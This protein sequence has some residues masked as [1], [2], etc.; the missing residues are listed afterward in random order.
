MGTRFAEGHSDASGI[1][2]SGR[3]DLAVELHVGVAA[4]D[5]CGGQSFEDWEKAV[6]GG[7]SSEDVVLVLGRCVAEQDGS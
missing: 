3:S 5:C 6:F 4:D 2:D 7:Q 1:D